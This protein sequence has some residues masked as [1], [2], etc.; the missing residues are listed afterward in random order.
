M[1]EAQQYCVTTAVDGYDGLRQAAAARPDIALVDIGLPGIDGY[2]VAR[3][4]RRDPATR[5]VRLIALTGYGQESDRVRALDAGFDA[6][7]V[8]P[9]DMGR[10]MAVM[11]SA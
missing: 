11:E 9:V 10:L 7:L 3:R 8:K 2:E 5:N 6:H 1:L 4:M